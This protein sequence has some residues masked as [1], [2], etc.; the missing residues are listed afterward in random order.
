MNAANVDTKA[1][2]TRQMR[3]PDAAA[4]PD[5]PVL[6]ATAFSPESAAALIWACGHASSIGAPLKIVHVIH[7]PADSPGTYKADGDDA[8]EPMADVAERRLSGFVQRVRQDHPRLSSL[9]GASL[10]CLQGLPA[11]RI[12][13]VAQSEGAQ[14]LVLGGGRRNGLGRLLHGSTAQQVLRHAQV[15]VTIVNAGS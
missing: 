5:P 12:L 11:A 15:P 13:D 14:I 1:P 9:D 7:D 3:T 2:S 10:L 4:P 6:L 8:L